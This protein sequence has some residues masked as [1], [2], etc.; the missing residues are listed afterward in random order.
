MRASENVA[1][2]V[3]EYN[4]KM[5]D[6]DLLLEDIENLKDKNIKIYC[7]SEYSENY[8]CLLNKFDNFNLLSDSLKIEVFLLREKKGLGYALN[9]GMSII[10]ENLIVRHDIG[11]R[12]L[13]NRLS[14]ARKFAKNYP[15]VGIF[16]SDAI[17][18]RNGQD[19]YCRSPRNMSQLLKKFTIKN[20]I[21]HP[22]VVFNNAVLKQ[23]NL[24]YDPQLRFCEDLDL[25]LRAIKSRVKF[26]R[27]DEPTLKY[28]RPK[29]LRADGNWHT[30]LFVRKRS[31][32][33]PNLIVSCLGIL[34]VRSFLSLPD[35]LK[36]ILYNAR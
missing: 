13:S 34:C 20:P 15:D 33:S 14:T 32:P 2:L 10:E 8:K 5:E 26:C 28:T 17:E 36:R 19:Q 29:T 9:Y 30:N 6:I 31:F 4:S 1:I 22:T 3:P 11:D 16:Y 12:M 18:V 24:N 21:I 25:W 35:S 7:I 23:Y 27:I